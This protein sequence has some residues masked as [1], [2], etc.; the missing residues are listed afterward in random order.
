MCVCRALCG[1][2]RKGRGDLTHVRGYKNPFP[3][4]II[5]IMSFCFQ[6]KMYII[7]RIRFSSL[8]VQ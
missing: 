7:F 4:I 3:A 2:A 8:F 1:K 6:L 5:S